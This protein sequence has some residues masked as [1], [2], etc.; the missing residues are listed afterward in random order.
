[1]LSSARWL[2]TGSCLAR[3]LNASTAA[4]S[5]PWRPSLAHARY[6]SSA[7]A[8]ETVEPDVDAQK[9]A[10][11]AA[12]AAEISASLAQRFQLT[13]TDHARLKQQRNIGISAHIDSGKTTL[14]ERILY[15]TGRIREIHEV[16]VLRDCTLYVASDTIPHRSA[17]ATRLARRWTAWS[18][19]ARKASPS[20]VR[21]RTAIGTRFRL[22]TAR[23]TTL[24]LISLTHQVR[25]HACVI[26][27]CPPTRSVGHVDFTIE[28]ER[29]LR[30]LDGA[31]LV[32]C[33]VSGVQVGL[34]PG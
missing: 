34:H 9:K 12:A 15:Y 25:M 27:L 6:A 3:R 22:S 18:S 21:R 13:E 28:V 30:V 4:R 1:M 33:A 5:A 11:E 19:S 32:L 20:R 8:A 14:T 31:V 23:R 17:G 29:A 2:P 10:A 16:R 24:P 7:A 26:R